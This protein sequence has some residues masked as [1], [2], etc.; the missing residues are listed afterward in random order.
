ML[1]AHMLL[2]V[3]DV[4]DMCLVQC[5][6][7]PASVAKFYSRPGFR[8][9]F[10]QSVWQTETGLFHEDTAPRWDTVT[11]KHVISVAAI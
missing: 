3:A 7:I 8:V 11:P 1:L 5:T 2:I 9:N 4:T 10:N 6:H